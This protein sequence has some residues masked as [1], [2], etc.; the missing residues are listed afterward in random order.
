MRTMADPDDRQPASA[1]ACRVS[2]GDPTPRCLC[3]IN[4]LAMA[5]I[6]LDAAEQY[7]YSLARRMLEWNSVEPL[8]QL[9]RVQI[10]AG[11]VHVTAEAREIVQMVA[12]TSG[13]SAFML[14][15]PMQRYF[16]DVSMMATHFYHDQ[17][18]G[19]EPLGRV[20]VGLPPNT[21]LA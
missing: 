18:T 19:F 5:R 17:D 12:A 2:A 21:R 16:R 7:L 11:V 13:S 20:M 6:R 8:N 9:Q 3:E 4:R 10:R 15:Q 14:D 1:D